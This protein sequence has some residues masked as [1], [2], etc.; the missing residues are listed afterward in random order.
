MSAPDPGP[1]WYFLLGAVTGTV[2]IGIVAMVLAARG[3]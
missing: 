2:I 3:W 1:G